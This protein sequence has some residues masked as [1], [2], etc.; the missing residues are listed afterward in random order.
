M[1]HP[2]AP[3]LYHH[4]QSA[5]QQ[6]EFLGNHDPRRY[7][8][9]IATSNHSYTMQGGLMT[10][11]PTQQPHMGGG[12]GGGGM[13]TSN[14][15]PNP[16]PMAYRAPEHAPFANNIYV[17]ADGQ[18][19]AQMGG[20]TSMPMVATT[21]HYAYTGGAVEMPPD[22]ML[23]LPPTLNNTAAQGS[24]LSQ[25]EREEEL[26][27]QLL[28]ARRNRTQQ[29]GMVANDSLAD[30]LMRLRQSRGYQGPGFTMGTN[31]SSMNQSVMDT[32]LGGS[33]PRQFLPD[34]N[35]RIDRNPTRLVDART[36]DM[37]DLSQRMQKQR[38]DGKFGP[39]DLY[40][41]EAP[42][43][44]QKRAHRK[45]PA[46]M[47]RR[48]LSAYNLFFSE[49]RERILKEIESKEGEVKGSEDQSSETN[50][51]EGEGTSKPKAFL[52]PLVAM[53]KK[54]RPHRKTHGKIS[55]QTLA[56]M[57][58]ERWKG[59]TEERRKYYQELAEEDAKRQKAAME[60][61]HAKQSAQKQGGEAAE[62]LPEDEEDED[63]DD[64]DDDDEEEEEEEGN[65]EGIKE[66]ESTRMDPVAVDKE[67]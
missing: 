16:Y 27:L 36:Q 43:K 41:E 11:D 14:A 15:A 21:P 51:E 17:T 24:F 23:P 22:P 26:L 64:D 42:P 45:K 63:N 54:R 39:L 37:M 60:E 47:P 1:N 4:P 61:Y 19:I 5:I 28:I 56:R 9:S 55:F 25:S 18:R 50:E 48:P 2:P 7:G 30:E 57:V 3:V 67:A 8:M 12:G 31:P 65:V 10:M 62:K 59:L 6:T 33:M 13:T 35:G 38:T 29:T 66:K 44:K 52:R 46:D 40:T 53:E 32:S 34:L 58:G 49:E 20:S